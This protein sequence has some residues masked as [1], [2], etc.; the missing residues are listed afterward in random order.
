MTPL[1]SFEWKKA[2]LRGK[3]DFGDAERN[4][5]VRG[6]DHLGALFCTQC[7]AYH[8]AFSESDHFIDIRMVSSYDQEV[9]DSL[10]VAHKEE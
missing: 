6:S 7:N 9:L 1:F 4:F 2:C 10:G 3:P 8:I 5:S